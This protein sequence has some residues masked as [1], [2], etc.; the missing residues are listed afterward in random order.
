MRPEDINSAEV[1]L[2][3]VPFPGEYRDWLL[4]TNGH[5]AW[6]GEVFVM[7]YSLDDVVAV[8]QAAEPDERLPG[9]L[10]FGSDGCGELLAFDLRRT[11][12][13]VIL[14][15]TVSAGWHEGLFQA[16]SFSAFMAQRDASEP[17]RWE[18]PYV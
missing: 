6:F 4:A 14:V 13:P 2:G 18:E 5:E 10:A 16:P 1:Q 8:T 9:L 15:N 17:F 7:F 11:P 3:G 12:A